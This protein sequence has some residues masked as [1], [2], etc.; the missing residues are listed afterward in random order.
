MNKFT[1]AFIII[2]LAGLLATGFV[3]FRRPATK[4]IGAS[5]DVPVGTATLE[6]VPS[7]RSLSVGEQVTVEVV[8]DTG[9]DLTTGVDLDL[10]YD[11][12]L[13]ELVDA[14]TVTAGVQIG[15]GSLFD[16]VPH[17]VT[18]LATGLISYSTSQQPTEN[19]IKLTQGKVA[20]ITLKAK[21]VG[22]S[23]ISF[24]HTPGSLSDTNIIKAGDGRDL[25]NNATNLEITIVK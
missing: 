12:V 11:P 20:T 23:T 9:E 21:A 14:D 8:G 5:T 25:L 10:R 18:T 24:T 4:H 22:T 1:V 16:L 7:K 19:P 2:I 15:A 3:Y 6:L 13:F 17:N